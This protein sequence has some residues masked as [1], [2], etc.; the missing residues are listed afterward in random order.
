VENKQYDLNE[1][2]G[3]VNDQILDN[4]QTILLTYWSHD[5]KATHD[6]AVEANN[7]KKKVHL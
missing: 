4:E 5:G 2:S 3:R 7:P 1:D 6:W